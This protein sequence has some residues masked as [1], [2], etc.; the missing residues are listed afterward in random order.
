[1]IPLFEQF[2]TESN[3]E[4]IRT[5]H[6]PD[7]NGG[8]FRYFVKSDP[9]SVMP[10]RIDDPII[11]V[12]RYVKWIIKLEQPHMSTMF[13]D[14]F[15]L[16]PRQREDMYKYFDPL[17]FFH[18]N[19]TLLKRGGVELDIFKYRSLL[20]LESVLQPYMEAEPDE[21]GISDKQ[22][23]KEEADK[24]YEDDEW[25]IVI[26]RSERASCIYGRGTRW[27]TA[28][29]GSEN[30]F[31]EYNDKG[32]LYININKKTGQKLQFH[33]EEVQF[34]DEDDDEIDI[35]SIMKAN[36]GLAKFYLHYADEAVT[37][38]EIDGNKIIIGDAT[39]IAG[40]LSGDV[41]SKFIES[42]LTYE[43]H[44][45][46]EPPPPHDDI[47]EYVSE[48]NRVAIENLDEERR[49]E[50]LEHSWRY[51]ME[52]TMADDYY[53]H[54]MGILADHYDIKKS[55][56]KKSDTL[57]W[58]YESDSEEDLIS[59]IWDIYAVQVSHG[60][61]EDIVYEQFDGWHELNIH[62]FNDYI[63]SEL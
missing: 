58:Y 31:D 2:I 10:H 38:D 53:D 56:I 18:D 4:D 43:N 17:K 36:M 62:M 3:A 19:K 60:D 47:W 52:T 45:D 7:I 35:D 6:Y 9:T 32:N 12:G 15:F 44:F 37:T 11:K 57:S 39:D 46:P 5:K 28:S 55:D 40:K 1:M 50:V 33:F 42:I 25:L 48:E 49:T 54:L 24:V 30:Y 59:V 41:N 14:S 29:T 61:N 13:G 51:S 63:K 34:M 22:I 8:D 27:C 16:S 21:Y 26:P 20:E 23:K